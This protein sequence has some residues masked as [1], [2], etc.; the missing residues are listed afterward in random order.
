MEQ[1][2][3]VIEIFNISTPLLSSSLLRLKRGSSFFWNY[4]FLVYNELFRPKNFRLLFRLHMALCASCWA[5][6]FVRFLGFVMTTFAVLVGGVLHR[7][8]LSFCLLFVT[9]FAQ[10]ASSLALLPGMVAL[11]AIDFICFGMFLMAERHFSIR[12]VEGNHI[13]CSKSASHHHD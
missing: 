7:N 12:N 8:S 10:F 1:A 4:P 6:R 2:G 5:G 9:V 11:Y 3:K 13:L